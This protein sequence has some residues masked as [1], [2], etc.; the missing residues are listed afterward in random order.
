[1]VP[2]IKY[3]EFMKGL[4]EATGDRGVVAAAETFR[5]LCEGNYFRPLMVPDSIRQNAVID[6]K[7]F[8]HIVPSASNTSGTSAPDVLPDGGNT[9]SGHCTR[10][11][12]A[13]TR[14]AKWEVPDLISGGQVTGLGKYKTDVFQSVPI[15]DMIE[16]A[17]AILPNPMEWA[18][19]LNHMPMKC[20]YSITCP[21]NQNGVY[22]GDGVGGGSDSGGGGAPS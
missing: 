6:W 15:E 18:L 20:G 5:A 4:F 14:E 1:M 22:A 7:G 11:I 12:G 13:E 2:A 16:R 9:I 19:S 10:D 17:Q 21:N 3:L 8:T